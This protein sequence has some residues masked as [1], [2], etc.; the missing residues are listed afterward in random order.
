MRKE[1][2]RVNVEEGVTHLARWWSKKYKLPPNH[3]LFVNRSQ[4]DLLQEMWED[5]YQRR[6]EIEDDLEHGCGDQAELLKQ[7]MD[8]NRAIE[9]EGEA[10]DA[11]ADKWERELEMGIIPDFN[12][13][14]DAA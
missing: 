11:L 1:L 10:E 2:A 3:E 8:L 5:M 13:G 4:A 6:E 9:G 12:E 7:L 14:V